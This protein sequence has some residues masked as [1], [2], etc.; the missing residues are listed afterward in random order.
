MTTTT[1]PPGIVRVFRQTVLMS[2]IEDVAPLAQTEPKWFEP[3][4][5]AMANLPWDEDDWNDDAKRTQPN[6][7]AILLVLLAK[8]LDADSPPPIIVPTW[9]G[10]VQAE[11]HRNSVDLELEADPD[12]AIYCSFENPAEEYEGFVGND[13]RE[14]IRFVGCLSDGSETGGLN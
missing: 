2:E 6:A 13:L 12:G 14:L 7:A 9:R 1:L 8:I 10:G 5:A 4:I 11:W 3:T